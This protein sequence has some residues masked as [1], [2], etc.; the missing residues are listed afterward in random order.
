MTDVFKLP[1]KIIADRAE[2][3]DEAL[4]ATLDAADLCMRALN[5]TPDEACKERIDR[6]CRALLD[7]AERIKNSGRRTADG[8]QSTKR[9]SVPSTLKSGMRLK[10]PRSSRQLTTREQI[11]VLEGSKLHGAVFPPWKSPP[12][13]SEFEL[14]KEELKYFDDFEFQ[15]SDLQLEVFDGWLRPNEIISRSNLVSPQEDRNLRL[16]RALPAR[17]DL[18]Q[19]LTADCS[20]VA[21]LCAGT[22]RSERG[23]P[24][25]L[26]V[27]MYPYDIGNKQPAVSPNGKYIIKLHFN[28]C[29]RKVAID[30]RLPSSKS[31]RFFDEIDRVALWL[32]I[33][34]AFSYGDVLITMGTGRLT[35]FEEE[36]MGLAGEHDYA[37]LDMK[38]DRGQQLALVKNPWSKATVWKGSTAYTGFVD[39][40]KFKK[41]A[42]ETAVSPAP[43]NKLMPGTFWMNL[44][45]IFQSFE[46]MYLNWNPALFSCREDLHF[47]WNLAASRGPPGSFAS[48]PQYEIR[49]GEGC[50]AWILL[51]RHFK[52]RKKP[53]SGERS[54]EANTNCGFMSLYA[55]RNKGERIF[56]SDEV[57]V[58]G[59]YVDS[60]NTLLKLELPP[61]SSYTI[62]VSEQALP[63]TSFA[64][65]LSAFSSEP[66]DFKEARERY[67]HCVFQHGAWTPTSSGGSASSSTYL[68]NPSFST[69]LDAMSDMAL[70]LEAE[71]YNVCVHV[72]LVRVHGRLVNSITNRDILGDSG[73]YT[74]GFALAELKNVEPGMYTVVC[75]TFEPRQE[76]KFQLSVR[77]TR[78]CSVG[79]VLPATAGRLVS[80]LETAFLT[81]DTDRLVASLLLT[82][83]TR[84]RMSARSHQD[85]TA[86]AKRTCSPLKLGL[87]YGYGPSKTVLAISGND[88]FLDSYLGVET[89]DLDLQPHMCYRRG[90]WIVVEKP[91]STALGYTTEDVHVDVLSDAPIEV[92]PWSIGKE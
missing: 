54:E 48:N 60:P 16:A 26:P 63:K 45:D 9:S 50:D 22:A 91:G 88:E 27:I 58:R 14:Q 90:L 12:E 79:R 53:S 57:S 25:I 82:R 55:Y 84:L 86:I 42:K 36:G 38:E 89:P 71:D 43:S 77:T 18:V 2:A 32:K 59:P 62:V 10:E 52:S 29:Y 56:K 80:R 65:T 31:S 74:K 66:L 3:K 4:T 33:R 19:D 41:P 92:G 76:G 30:D 70:L 46:S 78:P 28:G 61:I 81:G 13:A 72:K 68:C 23:H 69:R 1:E 85:N 34:Q 24:K 11:I 51:S 44:N 64:F 73:E 6:K 7:V 67:P 8:S 20:V 17:V 75:S 5:L 87:E 83:L 15:F 40:V 49:S 35:E 47:T 21:S 39:K 37:V